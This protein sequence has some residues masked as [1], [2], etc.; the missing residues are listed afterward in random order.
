MD[1]ALPRR[2]RRAGRRGAATSEPRAAARR[3]VAEDGWII[4]H[5]PE[6]ALELA[7]VTGSA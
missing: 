1:F 5:D 3:D 4:G 7:G 6:F 2:A